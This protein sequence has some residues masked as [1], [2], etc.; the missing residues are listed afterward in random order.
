MKTKELPY[1]LILTI[2]TAFYDRATQDP[3]IGFHFRHI[4]DFDEHLPRIADFWYLQ[5]HG[6]LKKKIDPPFDLLSTHKPLGLKRGQIDRW[7]VLFNENL[8]LFLN[9]E[10]NNSFQLWKSKVLHFSTILKKHLLP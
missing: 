3:M 4:D 1:N 5:L 9:D 6:N 2:V 10:N 8:D 7:V